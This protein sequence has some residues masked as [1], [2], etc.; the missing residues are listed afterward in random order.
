MR[1]LDKYLLRQFVGWTAIGLGGFISLTIVIDLF[2]RIDTFVDYRTP[3]LTI[4]RYYAYGLT[5]A[6]AQILPIALLLG[7]ILGINSLRKFNEVTAMQASGQSPWRLAVPLIVT[8]LLFCTAQYAVNETYGSAHYAESKRILNEEIKKR[9]EAEQESRANVRLLG[10]GSRFYVAQFYDARS[11]VLRNVSM[12]VLSPP[13]LEIRVDAERARYE[14]GVWTFE[15]GYY[16]A[17]RDSSETVLPFRSYARSDLDETPA[18]FAKRK[19]DPFNAGMRDLL[20]Y[21]RRVA[22]SG[23]ETQKYMTNFHLRASYP[24]AGVIMVFLGAGLSLRVLR[25]TSVV[26]GIGVALLAGFIF[27]ALIRAGQALGYNSTLP[28]VLAAWLGN[29]VFGLLGWWLFWRVAR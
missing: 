4:A 27:F 10:R 19:E 12:Q 23:G 18:D 25:G 17:F 14:D 29:I 2:E 15:R 7:T 5:T 13:T 11:R 22:E 16:R 1:I 21:A 3:F 6:I 8:A 24:I 26:L 20:Q 9:S 28:P